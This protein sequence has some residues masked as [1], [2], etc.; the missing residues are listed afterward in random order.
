V[1]EGRRSGGS[2]EAEIMLV[3]NRDNPDCN[4]QEVSNAQLKKIRCLADFDLIMLIS[5]IHDFGWPVAATTLAM[6]PERKE[7]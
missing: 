6:M 5:E 7:R 1:R 4:N 2:T 3:V